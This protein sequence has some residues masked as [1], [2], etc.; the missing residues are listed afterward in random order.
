MK[1][2]EVLI[3]TFSVLSM[4]CGY[5]AGFHKCSIETEGETDV[6]KNTMGCMLAASYSEP[7]LPARRPCSREGKGKTQNVLLNC[8]G[9][10]IP[11]SQGRD[12]CLESMNTLFF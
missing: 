3:F 7:L 1:A 9:E 11:S 12:K 5:L 8:A 4:P 10:N 2:L 6:R